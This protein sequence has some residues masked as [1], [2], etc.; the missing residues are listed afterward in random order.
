MLNDRRM[1]D[2]IYVG[3][4]AAAARS[5]QLDSIADNLANATTPGFTAGR[6]GFEAFLPAS[7]APDKAYTAAVGR[8]TDLAAG[9]TSLT[10]NPLDVAPRDGA[11]LAVERAD[12]SR[13][14]TRDGRLTVAHDGRLQ[15][16]GGLALS[17]SGGP[18]TVPPDAVTSIDAQGRVLSNGEVVDQLGLFALSGGMDRLGAALLMPSANGLATPVDAGVQTGALIAS[19]AKPL[20]AA[21]QMVGAQR[22]YDTS[23]QAIQTYRRLDER[24]NEVGKVR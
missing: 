14:Y 4:S 6:P 2:G 18:I 11:F 5:E 21:V 7:L 19:N 24:A 10:G 3:M 22:H 20:D 9:T 15:I 13:A 8:G 23:M 17:T 1:A 12:G 16:N